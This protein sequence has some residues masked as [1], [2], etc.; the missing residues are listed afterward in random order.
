MANNGG[1]FEKLAQLIR[2]QERLDLLLIGVGLSARDESP[3]FFD[4][5]PLTD[6][7]RGNDSGVVIGTRENEFI[8]QI[9]HEHV[10]IALIERAEDERISLGGKDNGGACLT[11]HSSGAMVSESRFRASDDFL[12]LIGKQDDEIVLLPFVRWFIES[13]QSMK[14]VGQL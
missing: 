8:A 2:L 4:N 5:L 9:K 3:G 1:E 13:A 10:R 12:A 14:V 7:L 6:I 11:D